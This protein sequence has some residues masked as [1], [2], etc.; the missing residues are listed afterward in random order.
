MF[1]R[2]FSDKSQ[3]SQS[4][5]S[6]FPRWNYEQKPI[7]VFCSSTYALCSGEWKLA[8]HQQTPAV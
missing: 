5:I 2:E 6:H 4:A 7:C 3:N 8:F 1:S